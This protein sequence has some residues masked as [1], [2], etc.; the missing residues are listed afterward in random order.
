MNIRIVS[1]HVKD[2]TKFCS[3]NPYEI[4]SEVLQLSKPERPIGP[5]AT[6]QNYQPP[7]LWK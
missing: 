3:I 7:K 4:S 2:F 1:T 5:I 6:C